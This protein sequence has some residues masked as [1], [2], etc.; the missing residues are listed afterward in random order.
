MRLSPQ[1]KARIIELKL[2][3]TYSGDI[4]AQ[5]GVSCSGVDKVWQEYRKN[6]PTA[7]CVGSGTHAQRRPVQSSAKP[8]VKVSYAFA[9]G[10]A[11]ARIGKGSNH[12]ATA[13]A[14]GLRHACALAAQIYFE[15]HTGEKPPLAHILIHPPIGR[16]SIG[17]TTA[18]LS[19]P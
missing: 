2:A 4:C 1:I 17:Q 15:R 18:T 8:T 5:T 9:D 6:H 16:P 10:L 14:L 7:P 3:K 13:T 19:A 12:I 11:R